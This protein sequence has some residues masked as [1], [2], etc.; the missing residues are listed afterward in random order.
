MTVTPMRL[1]EEFVPHACDLP[2]LRRWLAMDREHY[3]HQFVRCDGCGAVYK[4]AYGDYGLY[5][6]RKRFGLKRLEEVPAAR[7]SPL[8][9]DP[10]RA[11][12]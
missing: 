6:A 3:P 12:R 11:S 5:W 4:Q 9:S 2:P 1:R 10:G 7:P 8:R